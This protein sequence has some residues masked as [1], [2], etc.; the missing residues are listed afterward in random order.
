MPLYILQIKK[1]RPVLVYYE[2]SGENMTE[3]ISYNS[4]IVIDIFKNY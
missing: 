3:S 4:K 1:K 2:S